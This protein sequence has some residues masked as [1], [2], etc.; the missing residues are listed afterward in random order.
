MSQGDPNKVR[1][2]MMEGAVLSII[3]FAGLCFAIYWYYIDAWYY[4]QKGIFTLLAFIP[5]PIAEVLF[6]WADKIAIQAIPQISESLASHK[7]DYMTYYLQDKTG[8]R[9]LYL[10]N[11]LSSTIVIPFFTIPIFFHLYKESRKSKSRIKRPGIG[12]AMYAYARSQKEIWPY[13]KPV[14]NIMEKMSKD[15]NLDNDWYAMSKIPIM[16]LKE[17]GLIKVIKAKKTRSLLT[18]KERHEFSLDKTKAY[19]ALR[20]NLGEVWKGVDFLS[21]NQRCV[22]SVIIPHIFGKVKVSRLINRKLNCYHESNSTLSK[23]EIRNLRISIE[24]E[25][26]SILQDHAACFITPFFA[27]TDF[28]DAYDPLVSSFEELDSE[29]DMFKKGSALVQDVLLTHAYVNTIFFALIERAWTYGILSS[30]ELL[31]VK[32]VDRDLFYVLSQ[33]GRPSSF[34]EVCGAWSHYLAESTLGFKVLSPQLNEGLRGLDF[35]LFKTHSNYLVH[36]QWVDNSKWDKLVPDTKGK[37]GLPK[38]NA[39]NA[40]PLV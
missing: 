2:E 28:E 32:K 17:K 13:I 7:Q 35:D 33:Q 39:G 29:V 9:N 12:N 11:N 23:N 21:F 38:A 1:D 34:V 3:A 30:S 10:L 37:G 6:F 4:T 31:W 15:P 22:M 20:E 18:R 26:D 5:T 19:L 16:W 8:I 36:E 40:T 24:T 14:V 27:L 25:V